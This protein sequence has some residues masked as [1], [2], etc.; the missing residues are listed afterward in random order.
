MNYLKFRKIESG[1][2]YFTDSTFVIG[3]S[4]IRGKKAFATFFTS[5]KWMALIIRFA[6]SIV[7]IGHRNFR[8]HALIKQI[9]EF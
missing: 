1:L 9:K 3:D 2:K 6:N 4:S 5:Y 7:T 8:A